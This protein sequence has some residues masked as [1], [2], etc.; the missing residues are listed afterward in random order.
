M[1]D[2]FRNHSFG[3]TGPAIGALAVTPS[4]SA[5]LAQA[6]RAVTI[7]GEGGRLSFISSR[8][9]QTY[10]TGE[11]PPGTYPLCARRI[12]ATGTT[13]TGLTGWI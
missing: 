2:P 11:L 6:V 3:P 4:D 8:D 5:D 9:G 7:G 12:R 10:T 1:S 13:A